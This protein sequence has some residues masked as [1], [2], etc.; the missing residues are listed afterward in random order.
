MVTSKIKKVFGLYNKVEYPSFNKL[1]KAAIENNLV[2]EYNFSE[3]ANELESYWLEKGFSQ[4]VIIYNEE[5]NSPYY[6]VC[7]PELTE[8]EIRL[9]EEL[10]DELKD[11]I[12][13][14]SV[15]GNKEKVLHD[16]LIKLIRRIN[17]NI[18]VETFLKLFYYAKRDFM[19][20]GRIQPLM[21][22]RYLEDIS[23]NGSD[24]PLYVYH[25]RHEDL[26]TNIKFDEDELESLVMNISQR[27][28]K[29]INFA[30]PSLEATLPDGSRAQL[31]LGKE[32][33]LRGSTFT[34]RKFPEEP[35]TPIDIAA[36]E[37]ISPEMLAYFWF[38]S[39]NGRNIMIVGG[40]A[41]GKTTTLNAIS[42]FI[43]WGAKVVTIEDTH[44]LRLPF[45]NWI[46]S[47][48][49]EG[50]GSDAEDID[51]FDLLRSALR[52]RPEYIIVGEIRG[53]E[54][55]TLFQAMSTGHT[56][57]STLHASSVE[58]AIRR[59][60]SSPI[61]VPKN[62]IPALDV[63]AVQSMTKTGDKKYRRMTEVQ[64]IGDYD[65]E[66][67]GIQTNLLS[68]WNNRTRNFERLSKSIVLK[69]IAEERGMSY[70]EVE[71]EVRIRTKVI[72]K[73]IDKNIRGFKEVVRHIKRYQ[74]KK[75]ELLE[76]LG[77]KK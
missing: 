21:E 3:S 42:L 68:K 7:E 2:S 18:D 29:Q 8:E 40:T 22:D 32:V 4:A 64:E 39:E 51:M 6:I 54:A 27:S 59:L 47:I 45:D 16:N 19:G 61:N 56:S 55:T 43:P 74:R 34:I 15:S 33:T 37:T 72:E 44:E 1:T 53:K 31:T 46:P 5:E 11:L 76:E 57:F 58:R 71:E 41:T 48:T 14:R 17:K 25:Q 26:E 70:G 50:H 38:L 10:L 69:L 9:K 67:G 66:S 52:Q 60:E 49:R 62:I 35:I 65:A 13:K 63:I 20:L 30:S 28:D 77:I 23:C 12:I 75:E 36:W 24:I 73:M